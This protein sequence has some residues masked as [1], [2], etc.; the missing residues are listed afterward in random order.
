VG[1][2]QWVG[3]NNEENTPRVTRF[4]GSALLYFAGRGRPSFPTYVGVG[5]GAFVPHGDGFATRTGTRLTWGIER[6]GERW[7]VGAEIEVDLPLGERD[8]L[9]R[10]HLV[11]TTRAGLAIRRNF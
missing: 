5:I 1:H 8:R 7:T 2:G 6:M 4:A 9:V 11:P 10:T 3:I